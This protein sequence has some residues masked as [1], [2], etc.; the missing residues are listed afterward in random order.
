MLK[1]NVAGG[2]AIADADGQVDVCVEF[3]A[4]VDATDHGVRR[5]Y[6]Y[7]LLSTA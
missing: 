7:G 3:V 4:T 6:E 2:H 1:Y 5:E